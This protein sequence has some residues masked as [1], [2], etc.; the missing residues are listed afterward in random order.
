M[1]EKSLLKSKLR[2]TAIHL[3]LGSLAFLPLAYLIVFKWYP[4]PFFFAD[5]GWQGVRIMLLVDMVLGPVLTFMIFNPAKT[6][7]ALSV[8]FSFI[9]LVQV[10]AL[11]YGVY[12]VQATSIWAVAFNNEGLYDRSFV[13]VGKDRFQ[14]QNLPEGAWNDLGQGPQ[15]WVYVRQP[16]KHEL[17]Q[18]VELGE[19]GLPLESL[20]FLYDPLLMHRSEVLSKALDMEKMASL[21]ATFEADYRSFLARHKSAPGGLYFYRMIG[22]YR[23]VIIALDGEGRYVGFLNRDVPHAPPREKPAG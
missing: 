20:Q 15:Y 11:L 21:D 6:R 8:D 22:F 4:G 3:G 23:T 18:A 12:T 7:L 17:K 14:Q 16:Q 13:A 10:A 1:W 5:G 19:K 9:A 2:A